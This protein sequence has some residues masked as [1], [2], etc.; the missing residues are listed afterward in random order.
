M[1]TLKASKYAPRTP[2]EDQALSKAQRL[3]QDKNK[4]SRL[5]NRLQWKAE[6][7][8]ASYLRALDVLRTEK[9]NGLSNGHAVH[10]YA[11]AS[12]ISSKQAESMFKV[13]FFEFYTLLERFVE[14]SLSILGVTVSSGAIANEIGENVNAL[15]YITNP[16]LHRTRPLA[17]HQFHANLLA[18]L[19]QPNGPLYTALGHQDVRIQLGLAK[20]YR[21][22]WK[23]DSEKLATVTARNAADTEAWSA[24]RSSAV[25]LEEL[26]L[27]KM[28]ATLLAGCQH[29]LE[30][31]LRDGKPDTNRPSSFQMHEFELMDVEDG[32]PIE[33]MDDA[34]DLD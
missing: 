26:E 3:A 12:G 31:V 34:M 14:L 27:H 18:A 13:D 17:S 29:S 22:R 7:L 11:F 25:K 8:M 21:N 1:N 33:Y 23:D 20:D 28:L 30:I 24:S 10:Q 6:S 16:S 32:V 5:L 15:K 4:A 19:E 2:A 9:T